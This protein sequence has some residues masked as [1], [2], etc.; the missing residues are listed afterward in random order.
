MFDIKKNEK[1]I[2]Q[3]EQMKSFQ[4]FPKT[5]GLK[6]KYFFEMLKC[7]S[8]KITQTVTGS[9][10]TYIINTKIGFN[11]LR[12]DFYYQYIN[13][14]CFNKF[15]SFHCIN[16]P[17]KCLIKLDYVS[18]EYRK[19]SKLHNIS[20]PAFYSYDKKTSIAEFGYY[21]NGRKYNVDNYCKEISKRLK[22]D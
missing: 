6:Y 22:I 19:H 20:G 16:K 13:K 11:I 2:K 5:F 12:V 7:D 10:I 17:S 4:I 15:G 3:E 14:N 1:F 18:L 8:E 21:L 9:A